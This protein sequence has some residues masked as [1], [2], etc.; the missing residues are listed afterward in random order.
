MDALRPGLARV[1][2]AT[3]RVDRGAKQGQSVLVNCLV[4]HNPGIRIVAQDR[5][6]QQSVYRLDYVQAGGR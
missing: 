5:N 2:E 1:D 3:V 6:Q 4:P